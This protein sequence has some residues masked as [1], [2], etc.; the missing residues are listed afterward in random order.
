MHLIGY[1]MESLAD[2]SLPVP[3]E[4]GGGYQTDVRERLIAYL[5]AGNVFETYRCPSRCWFG[6]DLKP[7]ALQEITDGRWIWPN[8][9]SHEV[10]HHEVR[11]PEEFVRDALNPRPVEFGTDTET[12]LTFWK[13]RA[14]K[15][16]LPAVRRLLA[17]AQ[18]RA[19][20]EDQ[21]ER[22]RRIEDRIRNL[23]EREGLTDQPCIFRDC[24]R[25]ALQGRLLCAGHIGG[26]Q[27]ETRRLRIPAALLS[28]V[29]D[30]VRLSNRS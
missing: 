11:L 17:D 22:T 10:E 21:L 16:R 18:T 13:A 9:L 24:T 23:E 27:V 20:I 1:W 14:E 2:I 15:N 7:R 8:S 6:C 4:C 5:E 28:A 26:G 25:R 29:E 12:D 30:I 19:Q 3:Q